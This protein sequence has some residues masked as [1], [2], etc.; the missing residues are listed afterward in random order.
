MTTTTD[1][2]AELAAVYS[3]VIPFSE[4]DCSGFQIRN[5]LPPLPCPQE[6][7]DVIL[8]PGQFEGYPSRLYFSRQPTGPIQKN[9][10]GNR[11]FLERQWH[12]YSW[13]IDDGSPNLAML[14][15]QHLRGLITQ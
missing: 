12:A 9:W 14:V 2:L 6:P 4:G 13:K 3:D 10:N 8:V 5:V 11:R 1:H 15:Q 7:F